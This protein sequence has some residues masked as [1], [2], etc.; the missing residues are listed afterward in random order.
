MK[1]GV[2]LG[3]LAAGTIA[4][5]GCSTHVM[6]LPMQPV[7]EQT[8]QGQSVA[9]YFAAQETP[10]VA[11]SLGEA[12]E[13]V[14]IARNTDNQE[15]ACNTAFA[16]ALARLREKAHAKNGNAVINIVTSFHGKESSSR[17][18]FTCGVSPSAAAIRIR[19]DVVVLPA[20]DASVK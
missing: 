9:L 3:A 2:W 7:L 6:S 4:L 8:P 16:N 1:H 11:S 13:G 10:P 14:R 17:N 5:S 15:A 20:A 19:G 18:D 12:K